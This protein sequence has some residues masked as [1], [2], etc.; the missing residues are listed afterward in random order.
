MSS[1]INVQTSM[2]PVNEQEMPEETLVTLQ[3]KSRFSLS[4]AQGL[5]GHG[6]YKD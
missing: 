1:T 6:I 2:L 4:F 5:Q 3:L